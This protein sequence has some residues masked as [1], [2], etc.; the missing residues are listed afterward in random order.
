LVEIVDDDVEVAT[1]VDTS[2]HQIDMFVMSNEQGVSNKEG[3]QD[4][5]EGSTNNTLN[6]TT[7]HHL[8]DPDTEKIHSRIDACIEAGATL[9]TVHVADLLCRTFISE[10]DETGEQMRASISKIKAM[11][12]TSADYMQRMYKFQ[13]KVR[14]KVSEEIKTYNQIRPVE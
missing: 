9:P 12:D 7:G 8:L 3:D 11:E 10:P 5:S 4:D 13:C 14:D 6:G 2:I 1:S